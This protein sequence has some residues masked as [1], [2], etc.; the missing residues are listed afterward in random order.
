[1]LYRASRLGFK[2]EDF[3]RSCDGYS[4]TLTFILT[5]SERAFGGY[6]NVA[7]SSYGES[8][9]DESAFLFSLDHQQTYK[10]K[11]GRE[12]VDHDPDFGPCFGGGVSDIRIFSD[13]NLKSNNYSK[14]G[15]SFLPPS[16]I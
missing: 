2:A 3:H 14:F 12:A 16:G 13:S 9:P 7:W 8:L 1:L 4:N 11:E 6:T 15:F 5:D 10:A